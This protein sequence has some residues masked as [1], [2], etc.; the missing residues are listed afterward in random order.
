MAYTSGVNINRE[1]LDDLNNG[2]SDE[3]ILAKLEALADLPIALWENDSYIPLH[4]ASSRGR[5]RL[6]LF[7][8]QHVVPGQD[9]INIMNDNF[10]TALRYARRN[11]NAEVERI[12]LENGAVEPYPDRII[13]CKGRGCC[14]SFAFTT[15]EQL[16]FQSKNY[17]DPKYCASC[18]S[19]RK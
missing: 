6:V 19:S 11:K 18:K 15:S 3:E 13:R 12:L 5:E 8:L 14:N 10:L 16:R 17:H 9:C 2:L 7:I 4:H 1:F